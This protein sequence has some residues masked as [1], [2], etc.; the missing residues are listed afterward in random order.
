M[1]ILSEAAGL[2]DKLLIYG[3]DYITHDGTG[4]RD[5]IHIS[6]LAS[7]HIAAFQNVEIYLAV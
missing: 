4:V 6:D 1:P 2:R 3:N 5:Y 7:D